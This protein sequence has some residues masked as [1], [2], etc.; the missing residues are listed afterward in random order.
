M[1]TNHSCFYPS[2]S[3]NEHISVL[4]YPWTNLSLSCG[5]SWLQ[6]LLFPLQQGLRFLYSVEYEIVIYI[7][8]SF[9]YVTINMY[10]VNIDAASSIPGSALAGSSSVL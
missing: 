10:A 7:M 3:I 5:P 6:R 2:V 8:F 1:E 4:V 9:E